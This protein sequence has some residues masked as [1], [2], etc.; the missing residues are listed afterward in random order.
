MKANRISNDAETNGQ[1]LGV[2][3]EA[4]QAA[5]DTL[6]DGLNPETIESVRRLTASLRNADGVHNRAGLTQAIEAVDQ[7]EF[8]QMSGL[9]KRLIN[10]LRKTNSGN[11]ANGQSILIVDQ[12]TKTARLFEDAMPELNG[13]VTVV[14]DA[15]TAMKALQD[16]AFTLIVMNLKLVDM[17]GRN[18][19]MR[20]RAN[21]GS[22]TVPVFIVADKIGPL[23]KAE[24]A[25]L[26]AHE[27]FEKPLNAALFSAAVKKK[28]LQAPVTHPPVSKQPVGDVAKQTILLAEDD[29]VTAKIIQRR[30]QSEGFEVIH[31]PNGAEA[32]KAASSHDLSLCLLDV[33]MPVMDG[34]EL[35]GHL[36]QDRRLAH[37]PIVMLTS[38]GRDQDIRQGKELGATDY[39]VKPFSPADLVK[40]VRL[41]LDQIPKPT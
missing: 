1:N 36:R 8:D 38:M 29:T 27:Y 21:S 12:D 34:F 9:L 32:L 3:I 31:S 16:N 11:A 5:F 18:L 24:C 14:I 6:S 35:L 40:K 20:I 26:G 22:S 30:L 39:M 17:D 10:E 2:W 4:F 13:C 28:L 19:L 33:Q 41:L 37:V 23:A 25:A 7:A 15:D